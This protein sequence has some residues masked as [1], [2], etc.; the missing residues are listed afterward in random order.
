MWCGRCNKE[1]HACVCPDINERLRAISDSKTVASQWC[2]ACD[3]H[4]SQCRC[5]RPVWGVRSG[6]A[7]A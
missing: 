2:L 1:L 3:K 5:E 6:G 7:T 4:H